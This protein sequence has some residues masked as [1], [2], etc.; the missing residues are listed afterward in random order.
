M[1]QLVNLPAGAPPTHQRRRLLDD[2]STG[3]GMSRPAHISLRGGQFAL[4]R[5]DGARAPLP[6]TYF[7]FIAVDANR[8]TSRVYYAGEFE[9]NSDTPPAC[10]SDNGTGPSINAMTPQ[11]PLC[12][13]CPQNIRG[14]D[15]TFSGK[16]TTACQKRKKLAVI[17]PGDPQV[18]L[19]EFQLPPGSLTSLRAY[20]DWIRTQRNPANGAPLDIADFITRAAWDPNKQFTL[21]FSAVNWVNAPIDLQ[22]MEHIETN[23]LGDPIVGRTDVACNPQQ[24]VAMLAGPGPSAALPPPAAPAQFQLPPP[25]SVVPAAASTAPPTQPPLAPPAAAPS[26]SPP[27]AEA[28]RP[29]RPGRPRNQPADPQA[30]GFQAPAQ[31]PQPVA[32]AQFSPPPA[33]GFQ[34]P[35]FVQ[36]AAAAS[37]GTRLQEPAAYNPAPAA[38]QPQ[39]GM[40][41]PGS[42]PSALSEALS[43]LPPRQ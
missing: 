26:F 23:K 31:A 1:N 19:Y 6:T 3:L 18:N 4:V 21:L 22:R 12:E 42:P 5:A 36:Q 37:P 35:S 16:A 20:T 27:Q 13:T 29:R 28:P 40:V 11:S 9:N 2:V 34:P 8:E 10:F 38:P 32:H 14:S 15:T 33:Q 43:L 24:V 30:Q 41:Q 7:D 39:F 17:I 25:A